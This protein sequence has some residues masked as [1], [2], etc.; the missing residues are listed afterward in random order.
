MC[1]NNDTIEFVC[2]KLCT[3]LGLSNSA[4]FYRRVIS[5][6]F[7]RVFEAW[8]E[9]RGNN[10][11]KGFK[12]KEFM[13]DMIRFAN[14]NTQLRECLITLYLY[15]TLA[16]HFYDFGNG[17]K[18]VNFYYAESTVKGPRDYGPLGKKECGVAYN[19]MLRLLEALG[20]NTTRI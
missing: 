8:M 5:A 13:D 18:G 12:E 17:Y 4:I 1:L 11:E 19:C 10:P 6:F 15:R 7:F 20:K 3:E 2:H 9:R 16:D 14:N